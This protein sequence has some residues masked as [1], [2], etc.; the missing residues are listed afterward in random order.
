MKNVLIISTT[1]EELLSNVNDGTNRLFINGTEVPSTDW[2]GSGNYTATVEGHAVTITKIDSLTG[3]ISLARTADYT[4][5]MRRRTPSGEVPE[6]S[7]SASVDAN[8]GTPSVNVTKSGTDMNPNFDFAFHNLKGETGATGAAAGFGTPTA[9]IDANTGTPAVTVTASGADTA[10]VFDFAFRNLKGADG[11]AGATGA[12]P[13]ISMTASVDANTGTPAVTVT[14]SGTAE[15]PSFALAFQ[16]LKGESGINTA[17]IANANA[18]RASG[19]Y[20]YGGGGSNF[21]AGSSSYGILFVFNAG[22]YIGQTYYGNNGDVWY[23]QASSQTGA[24]GS[25]KRFSYNSD[26]VSQLETFSNVA[27]TTRSAGGAYYGS[28]SVPA[29]SGYT[30][31]AV[32]IANWSGVV[33]CFS[34]GIYENSAQ[35]L[36][37]SGVAQT[38]S[39]LKL[40]II[41]MKT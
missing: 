19:F 10:K 41:Y 25:W 26:I 9:S 20:T 7:A 1:E 2:V 27:I 4:Y 40:N 30:P 18:Y 33:N 29:K 13:D 24:F 12:T 22:Y 37:T 32:N 38:I 17:T 35:I 11:A 36:L 14:K 6:I 3:N 15:N 23:R 31:I 28:V 8:T 34:V 21:P 5:E 39:T 16:N